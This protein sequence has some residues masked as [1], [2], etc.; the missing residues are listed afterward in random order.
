MKDCPSD[1]ECHPQRITIQNLALS[2]TFDPLYVC[3]CP[4]SSISAPRRSQQFEARPHCWLWR[5]RQPCPLAWFWALCWFKTW[6][7]G[8]PTTLISSLVPLF[9]K[10]RVQYIHTS[11]SSAPQRA[12]HRWNQTSHTAGNFATTA[13]KR[14][15]APRGWTLQFCCWCWRGP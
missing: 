2:S 5:R 1:I 15:G 8:Q 6:P 4:A 12:T 14:E 9:Q 10:Y 3:N 11:R 7:V 13:P